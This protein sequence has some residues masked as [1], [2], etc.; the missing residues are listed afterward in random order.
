MSARNRAPADVHGRSTAHPVV[1]QQEFDTHREQQQQRPRRRDP[2]QWLSGPE[3]SE[4]IVGGPVRTSNGTA[5][6]HLAAYFHVRAYGS[7]GVVDRVRCD[8]AVENGWTLVANPAPVTYTPTITVGGA[9]I[10]NTALTHY[11]HTRWHQTGWW[12][13]NPQVYVKHDVTDLQDSKAIPKYE[14]LTPTEA[15][16]NSVRQSTPPMDNGDQT[17]DRDNTGAQDGIGPLPRWDAV[18]AVRADPRAFNSMKANAQGGAVYPIHFRDEATGDPVTIDRFPNATLADPVASNPRIPWTTTGNP[19]KPGSGSSHQP[20]IGYTAY[21]VTGDYYYREEMQFWSASNLIWPGP[22]ARAGQAGFG[23]DGS[24]GLWYTGSIRGQAWAYR[25][26]AQAAYIAPD[27]HALKNHFTGKLLNNLAYDTWQYVDG[28]SI[29]A[30]ALGAMYSG[31]KWNTNEYRGSSTTSCRG[32][33]NTSSIWDSARPS[34]AA[35]TNSKCR[36]V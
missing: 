21:L 2:R 11:A 3:V 5:H 34:H 30:N 10:Y 35:T 20:S 26:L 23:G 7:G 19:N 16:L 24:A 36:S 4:W 8:A 14:T 1:L 13:G 12:G 6:P 22:S 32:P 28:H 33:S 25:N 17:D 29:H 27:A 18:Y 9:T 31:E 15:F